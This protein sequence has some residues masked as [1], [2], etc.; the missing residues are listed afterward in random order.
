M[1]SRSPSPSCRRWATPD[2]PPPTAARSATHPPR[3]PPWR[4]A[5]G[6]GVT[7][8]GKLW[9]MTKCMGAGKAVRRA[10]LFNNSFTANVVDDI[11]NESRLEPQ[12]WGE[13][14]VE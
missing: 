2:A 11:P 13:A 7:G 4:Q 6:S 3:A 10:Y 9:G 14:T 1:T 5:L 8:L 12:E